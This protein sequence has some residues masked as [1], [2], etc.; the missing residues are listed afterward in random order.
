MRQRRR[1]ACVERI[2]HHPKPRAIQKRRWRNL[3]H[4]GILGIRWTARLHHLDERLGHELRAAD[5][6]DHDGAG[7]LLPNG[8]HARNVDVR[9]DLLRA[10]N[11]IRGRRQIG[12]RVRPTSVNVCRTGMP[13]PACASPYIVR[14][15]I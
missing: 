9:S 7:E 11:E 3:P 6:F 5:A 13:S 8:R 1:I 4:A 2:G 10:H 14:E 12:D 15:A